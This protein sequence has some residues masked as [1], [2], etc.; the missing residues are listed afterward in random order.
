MNSSS[1]DTDPA[2]PSILNEK[3]DEL[4]DLLDHQRNTQ[5]ITEEDDGIPVLDDIVDFNDAGFD[6]ELFSPMPDFSTD[7]IEEKVH[8]AMDNIDE[9][10]TAELEGLV[11]IL[12]D[13][14][15]DSVLT[16]IKQQLE[17][18]HSELGGKPFRQNPE[19]EQD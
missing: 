5:D 10:L 12:K 8:H 16:E 19:P 13:S 6:D 14:I 11:N 1:R 18:Q 4:E 3:I 15:R 17:T 7:F 9:K 2:S